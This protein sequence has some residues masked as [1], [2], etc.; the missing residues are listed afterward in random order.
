MT[1]VTDL[2]WSVWDCDATRDGPCMWEW[3]WLRWVNNAVGDSLLKLHTFIVMCVHRQT[4]THVCPLVFSL[5]FVSLAA[6]VKKETRKNR[7]QKKRQIGE[8][9]AGEF[10]FQ[11]PLFTWRRSTQWHRD[12]RRQLECW[13]FICK[14]TQA[15]QRTSINAYSGVSHW[16]HLHRRKLYVEP[17]YNFKVAF[18]LCWLIHTNSSAHTGQGSCFLLWRMN[19]FK[20]LSS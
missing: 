20:N 16:W 2:S 19:V 4:G 5:P 17:V 14:A 12:L 13:L 9:D 18:S 6:G 8:R 10:H 7:E 15:H 1:T 3:R 11:S